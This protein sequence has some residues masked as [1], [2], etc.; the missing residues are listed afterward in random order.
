MPKWYEDPLY[1]AGV[2]G[3][4]G[5]GW[6]INRQ[7]PDG[8]VVDVFERG[9]QVSFGTFDPELG[10]VLEDPEVL[11]QGISDR[12]GF[13]VPMD[14]ASAARMLRSEG[15]KQGELRV[16]VALNDLATFPYAS[17]LHELLV[18]SN[19]KS[20]RGLYGAQWSPAVPPQYTVA[21]A[22]RYS[23]SKNPYSGDV[24]TAGKAISDH[25]NGIDPSQGATKFVDVSS[26]SSQPGARGID[27]I[28]AL[29]AQEGLKPFTLPQYG[30]DL[31]LFRKEA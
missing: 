27:D 12:M 13:Y 2:V 25:Q 14:Q 5:L 16:H 20:R 24:L 7:D 15:A 10:I 23:T 3:L 21:N 30:E 17:T 4:A 29:W 18:Y 1:I 8:G 22:R 26:L 28:T 19:D 11:R 6:Y 9:S 31:V